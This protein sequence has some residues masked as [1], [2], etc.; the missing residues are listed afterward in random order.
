[1]SSK[2]QVMAVLSVICLVV[3]WALAMPKTL[4]IIAGVVVVI[5]VL[6]A[7]FRWVE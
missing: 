6:N 3:M 7:I 1:M 5:L 2:P 4:L